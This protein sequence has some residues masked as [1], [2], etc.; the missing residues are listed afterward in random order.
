MGIWDTISSWFGGGDVAEDTGALEAQRTR[1]DTLLA[2]YRNSGPYDALGLLDKTLLGVDVERLR[3]PGHRVGE[4]YA[5]KLWGGPLDEA[6]KVEGA[7][8]NV[9]ERVQDVLRWSNWDEEK[10]PAARLFSVTGVVWLRASENEDRTQVFVERVDPRDVVRKVEERGNLKYLRLDV[11]KAEELADGRI[12]K[13]TRT[14]VWDKNEKRLRIWEHTS[15]KGT[16]LAKLGTPTETRI[17][18]AEGGRNSVGVDFIPFRRAYFKDVGGSGMG[19]FEHALAKI[20][21]ADFVATKLYRMLFPKWPWVAEQSATDADG[22]PVGPARFETTGATS[23]MD[24]G[25]ENVVRMP[26]GVT[27]KPAVPQIDFA[28]HL[29]SLNAMLEELEKDLPELRYHKLNE[30]GVESGRAIRYQL[31]DLV[32]KVYEARGNGLAAIEKVVQMALTIGKNAGIEGFGDLP[33]FGDDKRAFTFSSRDPFP[34]SE[35]EEIETDTKRLDLYERAL[36]VMG[37]KEAREF[38][39]LPEASEAP[40]SALPEVPV[41]QQDGAAAAQEIVGRLLG[42]GTANPTG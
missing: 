32:D 29:N 39:G 7:E 19:A 37:Q 11:P 25:G 33:D 5:S 13:F 31:S 36:R 6:F 38:A 24:V 22:R 15:P 9:E 28:S 8:K 10:Q 4:F 41:G 27:L 26:T 23:V 30:R 1:Y 17:L 40:P 18:S 12:R 16:P 42:N 20:D 35:E 3:S 34:S 2:H 21:K 14:E